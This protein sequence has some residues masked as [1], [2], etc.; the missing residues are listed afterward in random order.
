M[1]T[2]H[3]R[4]DYISAFIRV[5]QI[6]ENDQYVLY[7]PSLEISGY[8][9]TRKKAQEMLQVA[10]D[11]FCG[12]LLKLKKD[13]MHLE[14]SKLGWKRDKLHNKEFSKAYIDK[15]GL[16]RNLIMDTKKAEITELS[17]SM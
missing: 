3:I 11:D 1:E 10:L 17:I 2:L 7:I 8:G 16:L 15:D 4:T 14:L 6:K 9:S 5:F 12:Y 13:K